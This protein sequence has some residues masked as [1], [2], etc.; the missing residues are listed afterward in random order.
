MKRRAF[1]AGSGIAVSTALAGCSSGSSTPD[2]A[3]KNVADDGT[4]LTVSVED[5]QHADRVAFDVD[6]GDVTEK[7]VSAES[8]TVSYSLGDPETLGTKDQRLQ[9]QAEVE[10][11]LFKQDGSLAETDDW[12][13]EPKLELTDIV[14]S[15]EFEFNPEG[16]AQAATPV[17]EIT[18]TGS[19]P[20]RIDQ[21]VV[22]NIDEVVPLKDSSKRTG[23]A[24]AVI[25]ASP[26]DDRI[27]PVD[28][29][30][31]HEFLIGGGDSAYFAAKGLL[32]HSGEP[33]AS[34]DSVT[35]QFD[36]EVRWLFDER[37]YRVKTKL[38]GGIQ[39]STG[40]ETYRFGD[41][42]LA[43]IDYASPLR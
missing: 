22:L 39:E 6:G 31:D 19:G 9:H 4:V 17:F 23:F 29:T 8:P 11:N 32:T 36:V 41:Y 1:L 15:S 14:Q 33:P 38:R 13:F 21:L 18:N 5:A 12:T 35:Q 7:S 27:H 2:P 26:R 40:A 20:T 3:I 24:H 28:T 43:S 16:Y 30:G 25:A 10:V 42:E 34:V 37:R